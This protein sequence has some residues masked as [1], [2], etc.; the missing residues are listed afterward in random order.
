MANSSQYWTA[1]GAFQYLKRQRQQQQLEHID[2]NLLIA[3][4]KEISCQNLTVVEPAILKTV[5]RV[6]QRHVEKTNHLPNGVDG[7]QADDHAL[8]NIKH[9]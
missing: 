6:K 2:Q 7:E 3:A 9:Y 5:Q 8:E 1:V 4:A